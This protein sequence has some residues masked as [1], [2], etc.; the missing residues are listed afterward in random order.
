MST[1]Q[2]EWSSSQLCIYCLDCAASH[3]ACICLD[4]FL[5]GDHEGHNYVILNTSGNC[6]CGDLE[7]WKKSG[8]CSKHRLN[9][10]DEENPENYLDEKLRTILTDVI[11]RASL[12]SLKQQSTKNL[13]SVSIIIQFLSS[14]LQFGDGF[15]RLICRSLTEKV[16]FE[17][18]IRGI[19]T[20]SFQFNQLLQHFIGLLV[21]D[22]LFK[23]NS[24]VIFY[25]LL[26]DQVYK[27][28]LSQIKEG[29]PAFSYEIWDHFYFHF[30]HEYCI[31]HSIEK[32]KIGTGLASTQK[33][34]YMPKK[35]LSTLVIQRTMNFLFCI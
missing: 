33:F 21:N 14:F 10:G 1:C 24:A 34:H 3:P 6:D 26:S 4:C 19:T 32:K 5:N 15:R 13:E 29:A 35:F 30:F 16:D 20:Y 28:Y 17:G 11:F 27:N 23:E 9:K 18:L 25:S 8:I 7:Q 12:T 31:N 22:Q 2:K